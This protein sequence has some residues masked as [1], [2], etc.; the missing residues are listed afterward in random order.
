MNTR[1]ALMVLLMALG[2]SSA[3]RPE[4]NIPAEG[5]PLWEQ[6]SRAMNDW[7]HQQSQGDPT[8][9]RDCEAN[10]ARDYAA[11]RDDAARRQYVVAHHCSL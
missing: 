1:T 5:R 9:D 6:C 11:L 3:Q 10:T 8:L 4:A 2:C 7:C